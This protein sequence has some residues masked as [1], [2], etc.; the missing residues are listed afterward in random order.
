M[1]RFRYGPDAEQGSAV[2]IVISLTAGEA[3]ALGPEAAT[4]A[5]WFDTALWALVLLRKGRTDDTPT[6]GVA[7][8]RTAINDLDH[9]LLP[10]IEGIRDAVVRAHDENGGSVGELALAMDVARSTA[11]YRRDALR[12]AEP[13]VW[14]RWA[15]GGLDADSSGTKVVTGIMTDQLNRIYQ[16]VDYVTN[17]DGQDRSLVVEMSQAMLND[18]IEGRDL[19][20]MVEYVKRFC[21]VIDSAED[22]ER[23]AA[24]I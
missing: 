8:W 3:E 22:A 14:E 1:I 9:R 16:A 12:N 21:D 6:P 2:D 13:G 23:L 10:R 4:L 19:A 7:D 18:I 5:D 11:Q 17:L 15:R 24:D 20:P